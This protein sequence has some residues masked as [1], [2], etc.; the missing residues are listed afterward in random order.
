MYCG[1]LHDEKESETQVLTLCSATLGREI[2]G[3][4]ES[5]VSNP[6]GQRH[7]ISILILSF[8]SWSRVQVKTDAVACYMP[9]SKEQHMNKMLHS[10]LSACSSKTKSTK[11]SFN[12]VFFS[13][14]ISIDRVQLSSSYSS[15]G[16]NA[17]QQK[18]LKK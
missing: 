10:E 16:S 5:H 13:K 11:Y 12:W 7:S 15:H 9:L 6:F 3:L 14:R 18:S 8:V 17:V 1:I 4:R 2:Q